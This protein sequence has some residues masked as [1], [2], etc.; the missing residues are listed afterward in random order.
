MATSTRESD[1]T[2]LAANAS[3]T[4]THWS[5]V[6]SA[7]DT[8]SAHSQESLSRLCH[9][10]WYP[11]YAWLRRTGRNPHDAQDLLQS[12]FARLLERKLFKSADPQRGRFRTFLLAALK[13][14]AADEHDKA[15]AQKRGGGAETFS[16]DAEA[17]E[18][19]FRREPANVASP[20]VLYERRWAL[21]L[22]E[23]AFRRLE[24]EM[25]R[26]GK[27]PLYAA[28]E[29]HLLGEEPAEAYP[30]IA[31]RLAMSPG[32]VKIAAHRLRRRFREL[33]REEIAQTVATPGEIDD[34]RRKLIAALQ[35]PPC[36]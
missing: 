12:F 3:F 14:F 25:T 4:T 10:Y 28:L 35:G 22:L 21:T 6:L 29:P 36:M 31:E 18:E 24:T 23:T 32:A 26:D 7:G 30:Q 34:E 13:N 19:N 17:A 33:L 1:E 8:A 16:L 2:V 5:V 11:L 15:Q 27:Q 20:D 9:S